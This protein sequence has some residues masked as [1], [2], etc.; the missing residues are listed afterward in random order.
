MGVVRGWRWAEKCSA[1]RAGGKPESRRSA[2]GELRAA[3]EIEALAPQ[4]TVKGLRAA[5]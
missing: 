5:L 1:L 2:P 4:D 3:D